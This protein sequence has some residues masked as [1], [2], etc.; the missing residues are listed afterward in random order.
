MQCLVRIGSGM[1]QHYF[2][3]FFINNEVT[4]VIITDIEMFNL[5]IY[6]QNYNAPERQT[7]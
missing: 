6:W 4:K 1:K 7:R 5:I 3:H 2:E